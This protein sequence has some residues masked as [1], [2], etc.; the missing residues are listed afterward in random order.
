MAESM[1]KSVSWPTPPGPLYEY[2][3]PPLIEAYMGATFQPL[4]RI[5]AAH[6]GLFWATIK[7]RFP[8]LQQH[9]PLP[10]VTPPRVVGMQGD[11]PLI[12]QMVPTIRYWFVDARDSELIQVQSDRLVH[13][14]RHKEGGSEYPRYRTLRQRFEE[15]WLAYTAFLTQEGVGVPSVA[16]CEI[17][18]VNRIAG[19][20]RPT[21]AL[22]PRLDGL[23]R[24]IPSLGSQAVRAQC[25]YSLPAEMGDVLLSFN[26][27][28]RGVGAEG[29]VWQLSLV[30][31]GDPRGNDP[32]T[33][34]NWFDA[35]RRWL[36]H[37]FST[38]VHPDARRS[39]GE[40]ECREESGEKEL[41]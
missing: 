34:L 19:G 2:D 28:Q 1:P 15:T 39:W 29:S 30:A 7:D 8:N 37:C 6:F 24:A 41:R 35:A 22:F 38:V 32:A 13:N 18:Y 21:S 33:L 26:Q 5:Q 16:E 4:E 36:N 25:R 11:E 3:R 23:D 20:D 9:D 27:L 14:W 17:G 31:K 10:P 40:R 12:A